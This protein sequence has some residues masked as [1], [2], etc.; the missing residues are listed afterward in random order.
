[1][2]KFSTGQPKGQSKYIKQITVKCRT[3]DCSNKPLQVLALQLGNV[4]EDKC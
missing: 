4:N 1:M 3:I 2:C